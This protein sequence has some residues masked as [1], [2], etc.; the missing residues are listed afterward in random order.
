ML[1]ERQ[2]LLQLA[3]LH[4]YKGEAVRER[5]S[6]VGTVLKPAPP[7]PEQFFGDVDYLNPRALEKPLSNV[8]GL[9]VMVSVYLAPII[10]LP[11]SAWEP[12][13]STLRVRCN[14]LPGLLRL[15]LFG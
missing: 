14:G 2:S 4:H 12:T 15:R 13:C 1:V 11:C 3:S 10:S 7:I 6:F 5:V 9:F 8:D